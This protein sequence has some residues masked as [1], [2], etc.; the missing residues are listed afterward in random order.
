MADPAG[1]VDPDDV[2]NPANYRLIAPGVNADLET[3]SCAS[4]SGDDVELSVT[5]VSHDPTTNTVVLDVSGSLPPSRYRLLECGTT[6][7]EDL[8]GEALDGDGDGD[9]GDDF[10]TDL[11]VDTGNLIVNGH[12]DCDLAGWST[13]PAT[14]GAVTWDAVDADGSN[15]SG[16]VH[17]V[18]LSVDTSFSVAQCV[19]VSGD[20][21]GILSSWFRISDDSIGL[22][23]YVQS[24]ELF[25]GADC[26]GALVA[27]GSSNSVQFGGTG[28]WVAASAVVPA[29]AGVTSARC[30]YRLDVPGGGPFEGWIDGMTYRE[31]RPDMI[32]A[33]DFDNGTTGAWSAAVG[34]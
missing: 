29:T 6:T 31:N 19:P 34:E 33:D 5:G 23:G 12:L 21:G 1:S 9:G 8:V 16:A 11:R 20:G 18:Q 7:L 28:G 14:A 15:Q 2:T 27:S 25:A 32:F 3:A 26:S 30:R 22:F 4:L 13:Q 17:M 10:L 24:Y